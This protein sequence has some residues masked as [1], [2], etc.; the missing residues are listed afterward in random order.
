MFI[1][2][3]PDKTKMNKLTILETTETNNITHFFLNFLHKWKLWIT[4]CFTKKL[5]ITFKLRLIVQ[6]YST[7]K[8]L[9][10]FFFQTL[11]NVSVS[12]SLMFKMVLKF[13]YSVMSQH[14]LLLLFVLSVWV[15][16]PGRKFWYWHKKSNRQYLKI[17]FTWNVFL[18]LEFEKYADI[19]ELKDNFWPMIV[20]AKESVIYLNHPLLIIKLKL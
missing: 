10:I 9:L 18:T 14:L 16:C 5:K 20:K 19:V 15:E 2:L 11:K 17:C 3:A 6:F 13:F 12:V 8:K 7:R 1:A 4:S